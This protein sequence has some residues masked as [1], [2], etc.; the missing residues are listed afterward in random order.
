LL[1]CLIAV[2]AVRAC[3]GLLVHEVERYA[4]L[5]IDERDVVGEHVVQLACDP[6]P[7]FAR[8]ASGLLLSRSCGFSG[9]RS[10]HTSDFADGQQD[11]QPRQE[12]ERPG[13]TRSRLVAD[14][15]RQPRER[16]PAGRR[17]KYPDE[18]VPRHDRGHEGDDE[19]E[20]DRPSRVVGGP[21][22]EGGGERDEKDGDGIPPAKQER[23]RTDH[24]QRV[25]ERVELGAVGLA[26][27][28]EVGPA[29]LHEGDDDGD[30]D[31]GAPRIQ[32]LPPRRR[33]RR[34]AAVRL[35]VGTVRLPQAGVIVRRAAAGLRRWEYF[36]GRES[37][38]RRYEA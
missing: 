31:I 9:A 18:S 3:S 23:D 16:Q 14:E 15:I 35:H 8:T 25:G 10:A 17:H 7:L 37:L 33:P 38:T 5:H 20:E 12:A 24:H 34:Q 36:G 30:R 11:E 2:S 21:V 28:P 4:G 29:E 22:G 26:F 1:A 27:R 32:P 19:R 13:E 6:H